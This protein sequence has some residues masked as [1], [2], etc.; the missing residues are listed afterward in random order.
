MNGVS[1][2]L[3]ALAMSALPVI[4]GLLK[5]MERRQKTR[6]YSAPRN[7]SRPAN[8]SAHSEVINRILKLEA[9]DASLLNLPEQH[10]LLDQ[11]V[12]LLEQRQLAFESR[13]DAMFS[14][15]ME[16]LPKAS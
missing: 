6:E 7:G 11:R 2:D 13:I 8:G 14:Q 4:I 16:R 15:I 5:E 9:A 1:G 10:R 12:F 3:L